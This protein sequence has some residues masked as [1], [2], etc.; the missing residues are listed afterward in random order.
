M[1]DI[2]AVRKW[3]G[4][5]RNIA[6]KLICWAEGGVVGADL[7]GEQPIY[8]NAVEHPKQVI[9]AAVRGNSSQTTER[10]LPEIAQIYKKPERRLRGDRGS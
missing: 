6:P 7:K 10:S 5:T 1:R 8:D 3:G 9:G 2:S 4:A